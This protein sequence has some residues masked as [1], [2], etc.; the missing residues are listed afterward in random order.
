MQDKSAPLK[1]R[2][3]AKRIFTRLQEEYP[4][5]LSV[6]YR[7]ICRYV[8]EKKKE[9]YK[10]SR[11]YIPLSHPSGEAQV[12]FGKAMFYEND[13]A[14]NGHYLSLSF[15]YSNAAYTQVFKGENQEC[16]LEGLKTIFEYMGKVPYKIWFDNL[17]AAVV[18]GKNKTRSLVKQFEQFSLHYGF[19]ATFCNPNSGHEKGHVENKI[20]YVRRN[21]FVPIPRFTSL[22]DYNKELLLKSDSDMDRKHYIKDVKI[23]DLFEKDKKQMIN[24]PIGC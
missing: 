6:G 10:E 23:S 9:L 2:H 24:L 12:D 22:E 4:E 20:G 15:P 14:I 19:E 16:L 5:L 11:G 13:T 8:S 18:L 7:S 1:Q 21:M 3:T 17:S